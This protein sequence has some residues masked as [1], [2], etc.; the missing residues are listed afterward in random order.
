MIRGAAIGDFIL[1]LPAIKV[2]RDAHP[3]AHIE[4]LGYK[5]IALLAKNKFYAD[6]IRS[7]ESGTLSRFFAKDADLPDDL[8]NYFADFDLIVSYLYD[9]NL[10]FEMNLQRSGSKRVISGP[11]KIDNS[12]HA[13][14]QLARP[15]EELGLTVSDFAPKVFPSK[16]DRLRADEFLAGLTPPIVALHPGSGSEKKNW[17][18]QNW[19][20]LGNYVQENLAGS[21]VIV[22]GEAEQSQAERLRITFASSRRRLAN[23]MSLPHLAAV[24][25]RTIFV[26]HDSGISHLA[27]ATGAKSILLFGPTNPAVWAPLNENARVIRAPNGDPS[28]LDGEAVRHRL[29]QALL[30]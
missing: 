2:L 16:A 3:A 20:E 1:T 25:E 11:A 29:D 27:A 12:A 15:I 26:G 4:V 18:I 14:R 9:P 23:S 21:L 28:R 24:L 6:R 8:A 30:S 5:H 17:P 19:I 13:A 7:L 10:I 22:S